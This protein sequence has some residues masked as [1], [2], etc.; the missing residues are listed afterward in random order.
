MLRH[1]RVI[2]QFQL[3]VHVLRGGIQELQLPFQLGPFML[4]TALHCLQPLQFQ[5]FALLVELPHL[6]F[7]R[8]GWGIISW[9]TMPAVVPYTTKV[10]EGLQ[11]PYLAQ[12]KAL[13]ELNEN[14]NLF[15]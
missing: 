11:R 15:A 2:Y 4:Y 3:H 1:D 12:M 13:V 5:L 10:P 14:F 8:W 7:W 9:P 6:I